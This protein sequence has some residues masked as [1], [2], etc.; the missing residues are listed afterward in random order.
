MFGH[1]GEP[2][3]A[4]GADVATSGGCAPE[5]AIEHALTLRGRDTFA[6]VVHDDSRAGHRR[7]PA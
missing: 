3:A 5:E 1:E 4:A 6:E 7:E 2:E